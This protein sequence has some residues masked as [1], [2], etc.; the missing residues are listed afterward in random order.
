M[1][2]F[3]IYMYFSGNLNNNATWDS[4][5]GYFFGTVLNQIMENPPTI[6]S[7][8]DVPTSVQVKKT[9]IQN[10][11]KAKAFILVIGGDDVDTT[12]PLKDFVTKLTEEQK[13]TIFLVKR[14]QKK[15]IELPDFLKKYAIYNFFEVEPSPTALERSSLEKRISEADFWERLTD[16]AY[17]LKHMLFSKVKNEVSES[18]TNTIFLAEVTSDQVRNRE[19]LRRELV[20][21]GYNVLPDAP[22]PLLLRELEDDVR[23]M[24]ERSVLSV[25]IMGELYGNSPVGTDYSYQEIQNRQFTDVSKKLAGFSDVRPKIQRIVWIQPVFDPYDEKQVQYIK[26]LKRDIAVSKDSEL[27][28]STIHDLKGIID[29]KFESLKLP[30]EPAVNFESGHILLI[31]DDYRDIACKAIR[32]EMEHA[33]LNLSLLKT[34]VN[35]HND[36]QLI[37]NELKRYKNILLLNTKSDYNWLESILNLI[38]RSKGYQDAVPVSFVGLFSP[39]QTKRPPEFHTLAID[40]YLYNSKN[41]NTILQSFI[42]K[43]KT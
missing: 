22:L 42:T 28:Q 38:A 26:R 9:D 31:A 17:D 33:S 27:I 4:G 32:E 1:A 8:A 35:M 24:L 41:I 7:N 20:L 6:L 14:P 36:L 39:S 34:V 19:R 37:M 5:F 13:L 29:Q 18:R 43:V 10:F 11:N 2:D 16:L 23:N 30:I 25:H 12:G 21:A 40:S 15:V 3:D